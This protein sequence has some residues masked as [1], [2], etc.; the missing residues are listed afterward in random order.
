M[1]GCPVIIAA[2]ELMIIGSGTRRLWIHL[3]CRV[4]LSAIIVQCSV[5]GLHT[6]HHP[7]NHPQDLS[8]YTY[9]SREH[10]G[11]DYVQPHGNIRVAV[12]K[13]GCREA[14]S[15]VYTSTP[16]RSA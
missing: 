7:V 13:R 12:R 10:T 2:G 6:V 9:T 16:V 4:V 11:F 3:V 1:G 5:P 15:Y 8:T 14:I